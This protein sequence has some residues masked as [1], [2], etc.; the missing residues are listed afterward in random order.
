M[1]CRPGRSAPQGTRHRSPS[2]H[3]IAR[4]LPISVP[5]SLDHSIRRGQ[6]RRTARDGQPWITS[7]SAIAP[8]GFRKH[9]ERDERRTDRNCANGVAA[10]A[11]MDPTRSWRKGRQP[12]RASRG[13]FGSDGGC[14]DPRA[15]LNLLIGWVAD[16]GIARPYCFTWAGIGDAHCGQPV[17]TGAH[18]AGTN[19]SLIY[20]HFTKSN[21]RKLMTFKLDFGLKI[22]QN[23]KYGLPFRQKAKPPTAASRK[24]AGRCRVA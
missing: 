7:G 23:A 8:P 9:S 20:S 6:I 15:R 4:S 22:F 2:D 12:A 10:G 1:P 24:R 11:R 17:M 19:C 3:L 13:G 18:G 14:C 21:C 5:A 16:R